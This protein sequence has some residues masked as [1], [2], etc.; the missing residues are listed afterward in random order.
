MPIYI[1]YR[2][3]IPFY[4]ILETV[5]VSPPLVDDFVTYVWCSLTLTAN[6]CSVQQRDYEMALKLQARNLELSVESRDVAAQGR[7]H[8]NIGNAYSAMGM[9]DQVYIPPNLYWNFTSLT[10]VMTFWNCLD[11]DDGLWPLCYS[12]CSVYQRW[13]WQSTCHISNY[14]AVE[15]GFGVI[16]ITFMSKIVISTGWNSH[17]ITVSQFIFIECTYL[18]WH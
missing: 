12:Q 1:V 6:I 13:Q 15:S 17:S 5:S 9:Y 8:G 2:R 18:P 4:G 11:F 14:V 16:S 3:M 10:S 7:A